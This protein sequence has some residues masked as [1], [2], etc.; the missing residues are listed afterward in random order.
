MFD[1][2]LAEYYQVSR[3]SL[4]NSVKKNIERF[5]DDFMFIL[6]QEEYQTWKSIIKKQYNQKNS[7]QEY[8]LFT[9][10]GAGQLS[11]ILQSEVAVETSLKII[12][13]VNKSG[14]FDV[15]KFK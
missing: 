8:Y 5:P 10:E 4:I 2:D 3:K 7:Y 9:A 1:Y 14:L 6:N 15:L 13:S 11:F 12:K